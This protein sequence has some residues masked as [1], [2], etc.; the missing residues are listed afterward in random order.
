MLRGSDEQGALANTRAI[1][2][3][4]RS[5]V[6]PVECVSADHFEAEFFGNG[7]LCLGECASPSSRYAIVAFLWAEEFDNN[8]DECAED[9]G[10]I[11]Y[12]SLRARIVDALTLDISLESCKAKRILMISP[13]VRRI[14]GAEILPLY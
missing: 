6:L 3:D 8:L 12:Q 7:M 9:R 1:M 11:C 2:A 5:D 4:I 13:N 14:C 10:N